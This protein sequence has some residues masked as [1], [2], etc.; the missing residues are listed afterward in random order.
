MLTFQTTKILIKET[1]TEE[2]EKLRKLK[3][4]KKGPQC[5]GR[6]LHTTINGEYQDSDSSY[7]RYFFKY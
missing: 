7:T 1:L 5:R 4:L 3:K 6:Q 2:L